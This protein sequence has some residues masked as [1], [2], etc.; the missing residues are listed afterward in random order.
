LVAIREWSPECV[1]SAGFGGGISLHSFDH[2]FPLIS[3][4]SHV[5]WKIKGLW[6][7]LVN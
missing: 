1:S 5:H 3:S 4:S 2:D 7:D 6:K